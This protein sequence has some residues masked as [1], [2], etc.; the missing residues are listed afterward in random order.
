MWCRITPEGDQAAQKRGLDAGAAFC[1]A[2]P[3]EAEELYR[4]VQAAIEA[5]PR[6]NI[7]IHT[8]LSVS[9]NGVPLDCIEGECAA[10]LSEHGM[11]VRMLKPLQRNEQLAIELN[12]NGRVIPAEAAVL[13][14]HQ[15]GDG[16]FTE[17]GMGLKFV[18][19]AAEDRAFI[20]QF[21]REEVTRGIAPEKE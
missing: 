18:R 4:S 17:P 5:T 8:R 16:P 9:L 15:F 2:K 12:V 1:I 14:S 19:I 7:R 13:Y 10:V 3:I 6:A 21:I 20:R 11:Y